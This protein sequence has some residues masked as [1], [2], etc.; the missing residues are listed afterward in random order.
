MTG[1]GS[2]PVAWTLI[3]PVKRFTVGKSR[4]RAHTDSQSD[5]HAP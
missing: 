2:V 5:R 1:P 3:I 4:L